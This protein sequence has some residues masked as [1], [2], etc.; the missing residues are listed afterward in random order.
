MVHRDLQFARANEVTM[1]R[2]GMGIRVFRGVLR[3]LFRTLFRVRIEGEA[4][5]PGKA[6]IVCANHLGWADAFLPL[7]FLPVEPR[8]YVLGEEQVQD[9]SWF[10]RVMIERLRVMIPLNRDKPLEALRTMKG[11]LSRGGSL[12]IFPEGHLGT[13][14]GSLSPLQKGAA[15]LSLQSG[16]PVLPVGLTGTSKL[17]LLRHLTLRVGKPIEPAQFGEGAMHDRLDSLTDHLSRELQALLPGDTNSP[18]VRPLE[19]WLTNLL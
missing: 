3:L 15:H 1:A 14:E 6:A 8:I 19:K 16:A 9:I 10:R 4:N 17:W 13:E 7:L 2:A 5:V 18:R 12:L 11:V